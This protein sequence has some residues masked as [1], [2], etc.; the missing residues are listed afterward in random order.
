[1]HHPSRQAPL[2]YGSVCS[3][4]EAVS[5]AWQPLGLQAAW[6]AEID[7]FPCAVLAHHHPSVPNLGDMTAI[8]RQ[9]RAGTVSAPDILVGGTPC[10]S[11]SVA[12][13]RRGLDDP[14]GALTLAYV[15]LAN[16]I[17]QTRG[18]DR[19][20][21]ATIV[22]E[23]VPGVLTDRSNAFGHFLGAL[24][25]ESRALEPPGKKWTH[26]GCV[27][28]PR[29]RIAWRVLDAQ[30]FGVAQR[31]KRVFL[32][33]S[34]HPDLDPSEVLFESGGVLGNSSPS[35]AP[36]QETAAAVGTGTAAAGECSGYAGLK[37]PYGSAT[38]TFG[39]G[40]GNTAGPIDVAACLTAA[41]GPKNDFEVETFLAQSV[42]GGISHTLGAANGGK[43][44]SEDGTGRGVPI[45]AFTAQG[46]GADATLGLAPTLRAGGHRNS[47]ANAGVVPAVAFAQNNRG[48]VRFESGHGQV[49]CTVLSSG[50]PGYGVPM[51]ACVAL[52]GRQQGIAAELGGDVA[53]ALRTS[54]GGADKPH[55][56][57]P[58]FEA[59]LHYDWNDPALGGWSHWRVRRLMPVECERLQG[60]PDDYT[61]V[62]YR[63]K[64]A[65]DAPR[66]KAIG[67]SMAVPCVAWLGR[68]LLQC[69]HKAEPSVSD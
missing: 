22:W 37:Q 17:D 32:V 21:P 47:H 2:L 39:F 13:A 25:G 27:S 24:A 66:Y 15:E 43:G 33:A 1:M 55:V 23:N 63:G 5:L 51:V 68:R 69:L 9:V 26:A 53:A 57:A 29:R 14:R 50:K 40:G 54:G 44:C 12:G 31:R 62:Q 56:L 16:A 45:I 59:H 41:P 38:I 7:P 36:W 64:P 60:M 65:A 48:E 46:S 18:H 61:L 34:G 10:Q 49:A 28:G 11:F 30:Y 20:P 42:N 3:G 58:T 35:F 19:R 52:R 67:N 8:A 4:I 6:F